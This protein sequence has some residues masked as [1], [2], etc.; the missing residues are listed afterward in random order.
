M[1]LANT[2]QQ[3]LAWLQQADEQIKAEISGESKQQINLRLDIYSIAYRLRLMEALADTFPSLH[4][5]V[6]DQRFAQL[7][8]DYIDDNPSQHFSLRYFGHQLSSWLENYPLTES[9]PILVEMTAFEWSLREAFDA[10]D[11]MPLTTEE[12]HSVPPEQWNNLVFTFHPSVQ[13][14]N[15]L[16]N[17]PQLWKVIDENKEQIE[18]I[19]SDYPMAWLIWRDSLKTWF[20]SMD[21]DEAWAVDQIKQGAN[22][23]TICS[24]LTEWID[25]QNAAQRAVGF[26]QSWLQQGVLCKLSY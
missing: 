9:F 21:V 25:E 2:Q 1:S 17:T 5:L 13:R 4:T 19:K 23:A 7:A 24:G 12:L 18:I 22:F 16:W 8:S 20:R 3:F 26:I 14:I 10:A 6:G 15:L 11:E